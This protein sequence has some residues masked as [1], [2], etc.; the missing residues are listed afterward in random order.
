MLAGVRNRR[1]LERRKIGGEMCGLSVNCVWIVFGLCVESLWIVCESCV[2]CVYNL[3]KLYVICVWIAVVPEGVSA[4]VC[5]CVRSR[6]VDIFNKFVA[7]WLGRR[8]SV[9]KSQVRILAE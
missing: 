5:T 4:F 7:E 6:S 8:T 9:R 3:C 1:A 2:D